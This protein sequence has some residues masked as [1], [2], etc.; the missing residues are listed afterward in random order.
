MKG[1]KAFV[2]L[3]IAVICG[4]AATFLIVKG[5]FGAQEKKVQVLR[6]KAD[7]APQTRLEKPEDMFD[8][9]EVPESAVKKDLD[10]A[11]GTS[12]F[13][14]DVKQLAGRYLKNG[15]SKNN[16]LKV[17]DLLEP[18]ENPLQSKL[19]FGEKAFSVA[20]S[21]ARAG[22]FITPGCR[23]D[24]LATDA[25]GQEISP[26]YLLRDVEVLA[27]NDRLQANALPASEGKPAGGMYLPPENAVLRIDKNWKTLA[28]TKYSQKGTIYLVLRGSPP[29]EL[30][31][32]EVA[33]LGQEDRKRYDDS[34]KLAKAEKD[35]RKGEEQK[36]MDEL[37]VKEDGDMNAATATDTPETDKE[38]QLRA[39]LEK[40]KGDKNADQG[41]IKELE[42]KILALQNLPPGAANF[43]PYKDLKQVIDVPGRE[44]EIRVVPK[45]NDPTSIGAGN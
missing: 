17:T 38:K 32:D 16:M 14:T 24:V 2:P 31:A 34:M 33:K 23:V 18:G 42:A 8:L 29:G 19:L 1:N 39:D 27:I 41:K 26:R 20:V 37:G 13:P 9:D 11:G 25:K 15:V 28:L 36:L 30:K 5:G 21:L 7:L 45:S 35:L 44:P 4:V 10:G 6:A 12:P 22:G 3:A 40:L 43:W